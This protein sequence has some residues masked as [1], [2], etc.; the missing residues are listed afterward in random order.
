MSVK[1]LGGLQKGRRSH[2]QIGSEN[3][4]LMDNPYY[5]L[6]TRHSFP[7]SPVRE[8]R[9]PQFPSGA[10]FSCNLTVEQVGLKTYLS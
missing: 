8:T 1:Y 7:P 10:V 4:I 2:K 9:E 3:D 5:T 6:C